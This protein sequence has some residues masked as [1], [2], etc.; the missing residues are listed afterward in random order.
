MD[1]SPIEHV[2]DIL[3]KLVRRR[4]PQ[5]RTLGQLGAALEEEWGK[6]PTSHHTSTNGSMRRRCVACNDNRGATYTLLMTC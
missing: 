5:P 6:D 3:G 4:S 2:W 1:L